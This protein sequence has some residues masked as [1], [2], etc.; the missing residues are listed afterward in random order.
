MG[1]YSVFCEVDFKRKK[2][3]AD[4][5][6]GLQLLQ[7]PMHLNHFRALMSNSNVLEA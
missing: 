4:R 2:E 5:G 1:V 6:V 7:S 3:E